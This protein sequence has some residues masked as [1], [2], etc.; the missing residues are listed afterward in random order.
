M[1]SI[2]YIQ[3]NPLKMKI[4]LSL[5]ITSA[6]LELGASPFIQRSNFPGLGRHR[7]AA[8]SIGNKGYMGLGHVNGTGVETYYNDW[9][10]YD[11]ASDTWIQKADFI[12]NSGNGELG[13]QGFGLETVGYVGVGELDHLKFFKFDPATNTWSAVA[14]APSGILFQD[15]DTFLIGHKCYFMDLYTGKMYE[16]DADFDVWTQKNPFPSGPYYS[17]AAFSING[18]GYIKIYNEMWKYDSTVDQ[19]SYESTFPG[20][21]ELSSI[22]FVQDNKMYLVCGYDGIHTNV[23]SETWEYDPSTQVWTQLEDFP[24]TARRYSSSFTI[25]N[26]CFF[27]TGTNGTN[28]SDFWEFDRYLSVDDQIKEAQVQVYPNPA[29]E[30]INVA[31]PVGTQLR[32]IDASGRIFIQQEINS[33]DQHIDVTHLKP[34]YYQYGISQEGN[35][36]SQGSL[37]IN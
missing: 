27:G 13:A 6:V 5:L 29:S 36:I 35:V 9:W 15:T 16:Y 25:G 7:A 18:Y 17:F 21:A 10:E 2:V 3:V 4:F 37:I 11:P 32:L 14:N 33:S 12:G 22:R 28:F 8:I 34:G 31:A 20:L 30:Y 19:W 26:R 24:G 1:V 23:V